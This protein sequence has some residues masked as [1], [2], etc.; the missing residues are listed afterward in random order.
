MLSE[1]LCPAPGRCSFQ[2]NRLMTEPLWQLCRSDPAYRKLFGDPV[3]LVPLFSHRISTPTL[4]V[5]YLEAASVEVAVKP[6]QK[7]LVAGHDPRPETAASGSRLGDCVSLGIVLER[8]DAEGVECICS[9]KWKMSCDTHEVCRISDN[10][11]PEQC[12][13]TCNEYVKQNT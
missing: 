2:N 5:E 4:E 7:L 10:R 13:Q 8:R 6:K 1:C 9:G 12:C 3:P 11:G